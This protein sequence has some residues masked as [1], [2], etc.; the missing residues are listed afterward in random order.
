LPFPE[1]R[2]AASE[3][4]IVLNS[5]QARGKLVVMGIMFSDECRPYVRVK[6][7]DRTSGEAMSA[8][9]LERFQMGIQ[10]NEHETFA[11]EIECL[12]GCLFVA[13]LKC[14]QSFP[15]EPAFR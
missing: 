10:L 5:H 11:I 4:F 7:Q 13:A 12:R 14:Q 15:V 3:K 8:E 6:L 9:L 1:M 2:L